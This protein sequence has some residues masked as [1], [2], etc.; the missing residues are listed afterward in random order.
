M[1]DPRSTAASR[2]R[3]G[4]LLAHLLLV[5]ALGGALL[6]FGVVSGFGAD[7]TVQAEGSVGSY[8]WGPENTFTINANG[9]VEFKNTESI[10]HGVVFEGTAPSCSGVP[11]VGTAG[12]WSG[13]C[14]FTQAGN[15]TS[16]ARCIRPK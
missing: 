3:K 8:H 16:T 5:T 11:N 13:T 12:T 14:T 2:G 6:S 7:K 1:P 15:T 4:H 10:P 9:T